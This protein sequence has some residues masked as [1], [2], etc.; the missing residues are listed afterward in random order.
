MY[1]CAQFVLLTHAY[2]CDRA[3][4]LHCH[5]LPC[6][7][8]L[9]CIEYTSPHFTTTLKSPTP[10][11]THAS[12]ALT[13]ICMPGLC[14]WSSKHGGDHAC[15]MH[16]CM[17]TMPEILLSA[18]CD[19]HADHTPITISKRRHSLS[20]SQT[21]LCPSTASCDNASPTIS[22][23]KHHVREG[24]SMPVDAHTRARIVGRLKTC[25]RWVRGQPG[26]VARQIQEIACHA[27][28]TFS[29]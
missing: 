2:A 20:T 8:V 29:L 22:A 28:C 25:A 27:P 4:H 3:P 24:S 11:C 1:V 16:A 17:P 15:M 6:K 21:R 5:F 19:L 9:A 12:P 7:A 10:K 23:M 26:C 13:Q 14:L 18:V